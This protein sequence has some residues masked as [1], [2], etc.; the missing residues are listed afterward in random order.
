MITLT[1]NTIT[2]YS[3]LHELREAH[4]RLRKLHSEGET[5][6]V[7]DEVDIFIQRAS[8]TGAILDND[9]DRRLAQSFL[10]YWVTVL[11]RAKRTPS[12]AILDE[13][14]PSL[15]P[16]LDDSLCPYKGLNAFQE[17]DQDLFFGRQRLI[18]SVVS[19][20]K[21]SNFLAVV[22]PSGSGKSSLV[23]AGLLPELKKG[24][25]EGSQEWQYFPPF[26]PGS[27]PLR[28]LAM[29]IK[30]DAS[31]QWI[32]DTIEKLK[33]DR[34]YL[35]KT[36][37]GSVEGKP[38]VIVIDQ[39]EEIFTL[40]TE[41][42]RNAFVDNLVTFVQTPNPKPIVILTLRSDYEAQI[43]SLPELIPLFELGDVRIIP[44][45]SA[46]LYEAIEEPAKRVGLKF[47]DGVVDAL[48][49]DILGELAGLPLLQFALLRLWRMRDHNRITWRAYQSLG[50]ARRALALCADEFYKNLFD[51]DQAV[52]KRILLRLARPSEG[53]EVTSNRVRRKTLKVAGETSEAVDRGVDL[54]V[55]AG[56]VRL[57]RGK[58]PADDQVEVAHEALIRNWPKLV[59]WLEEERIRLRKRLRITAA[60]E[61]WV[62]LSRDPGAL[63]A[64]SLLEEALE[65]KERNEL[66]EPENEFVAAS[67]AAI[68]AA[69]R[70]KEAARQRE[71]ELER[72]RSLA[73]EQRNELERARNVALEQRNEWVVKHAKKTRRFAVVF[74]TVALLAIIFA[75]FGAQQ[76]RQANLS[77][78]RA[79]ASE[80]QATE[81]AK[82]AQQKKKDAEEQRQLV[83]KRNEEL[84]EANETIKKESARAVLQTKIAEANA[85]QAREAQR[86]YQLAW[87]RANEES[88]KNKRE[89]VR[90]Q[91]LSIQLWVEQL[92]SIERQASQ[93]QKDGKL[94]DA[95]SMYSD[96]L[97]EYRT[98]RFPRSERRVLSEIAEIHKARGASAKETAAREEMAKLPTPIEL[99]LAKTILERGIDAAVSQYNELKK[100]D[101]TK[102]DFTEGGL[103]DLGYVL[104]QGKRTNEAI[105]IFKLNVRAY[106]DRANPYD[107][108]GEAYMIAGNKDLAIEN[109]KKAL[110]L[111]ITTGDE[112][113]K[114]SATEALKKLGANP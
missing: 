103:N 12:D 53:F 52:V 113:R 85:A 61:Q 29:S 86:K 67:V 57:T 64:G 30:P 26:V 21:E 88:E 35:A 16:Q 48:V 99:V 83:S 27:N 65:Y 63:L 72:A 87:K 95:L 107:S 74:A 51:E 90:F 93:L 24:E 97:Q 43:V 25:L 32:A 38:S 108:L 2:A 46:D 109:Y 112:R 66:S 40:C 15:A 41:E 55:G 36:L 11:Y 101:P 76:R 17:N 75:A 3:S 105:E 18:E 6:Q 5:G 78:D 91:V 56:L 20:L 62:E 31:A 69:E 68:E 81:S 102:Y 28:N 23:L 14:D 19:H 8:E 33:A 1:E 89:V 4:A 39:F 49:K 73:L 82:E 59:G 98:L 80:R 114:K 96:L 92:R 42:I 37:C 71:L 60:E 104:L 47:E 9:D 94:E 70:E 58:I 13:F 34:F 45:A 100:T 54:L 50:G 110:E 111:A 7:L 22:G 79:K 84:E 106:P 10:D 77:A 44:L